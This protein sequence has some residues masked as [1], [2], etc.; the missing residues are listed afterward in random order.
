MADAYSGC[1]HYRRKALLQCPL[2]RCSA[3][4]SCR[5]CHDAQHYDNLGDPALQ[6][7]FERT[8]VTRVRCT[9]CSLEQPPAQA[10]AGCGLVLGA[11]FCALCILY[12]DAGAAKGLWHC[13]QCGLC[14]AG[15]KEKFFHCDGCGSCLSLLTKEG[16]K[17]SGPGLKQD[18]PFC[19]EGMWASRKQS[20]AM[21]CGHWVHS[22]CF[23]DY[24]ASRPSP[25]A[26]CPLCASCV[27]DERRRFR[28]MDVEIALTPMPAN[29][30]NSLRALVRLP[31]P[32]N[33]RR[34]LLLFF[35]THTP[36]PLFTPLPFY[37]QCNDCH[38]EGEALWHVLGI[39]CGGA[40]SCGSYN[41]RKVGAGGG[42]GGG[43]SAGGEETAAAPVPPPAQPAPR[44][45]TS[46]AA[47][48]ALVAAT[49]CASH[50]AADPANAALG[51]AL[52]R[53][54]AA[55]SAS[56]NPAA[57][58]IGVP[59]PE[60][61]QLEGGGDGGGGGVAAAAPAAAP[62]VAEGEEG[63]EEEED[64]E[65]GEGEGE[66]EEEEDGDGEEEDEEEEEERNEAA[67]MALLGAGGGAGMSAA[68]SRELLKNCGDLFAAGVS[69]AD[70]WA[71]LRARGVQ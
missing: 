52:G 38:W 23:N 41:T 37:C 6:H 21:R 64:E 59:P 53:L 45:P 57:G 54:R 30:R 70:I 1:E 39:K 27:L 71:Y 69:C 60:N 24:L 20:I 19:L 13:E 4:V 55:A 65:D 2:P 66:E 29:L 36:T 43:G 46:Q 67:L 17:C 51:A 63:E 48:E 18:C 26:R 3:W 42:G 47:L 44:Y 35:L 49:S 15:G 58:L 34:A 68:Q 33:L 28:L 14:R 9:G 8:K 7:Q 16:H 10:C 56:A 5:F 61:Q 11:Y 25:F 62:L 32:P 50:G 12:D 31:S 22:E 40:A